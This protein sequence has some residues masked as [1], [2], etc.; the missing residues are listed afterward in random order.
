[1]LFRSSLS[2][3]KAI[4]GSLPITFWMS[5]CPPGLAFIALPSLNTTNLTYDDFNVRQF[6]CTSFWACVKPNSRWAAPILAGVLS[7]LDFEMVL[8]LNLRVEPKYSTFA[9]YNAVYLAFPLHFNHDH[10]YWNDNL[11]QIGHTGSCCTRFAPANCEGRV[12]G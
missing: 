6:Y 7:K 4:N 10:F 2:Q 9:M 12:H 11:R 8:A 1:M 5:I 3:R